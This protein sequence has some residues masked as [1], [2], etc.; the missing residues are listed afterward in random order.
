MRRRLFVA[1]LSIGLAVAIGLVAI[2]DHR[3]KQSRAN[4]AEL[5]EWYCAHVGT[6]CGGASSERIETSWERREI[7]YKVTVGG[8]V[9]AAVL[10][11]G[12]PVLVLA[13]R[14][15]APGR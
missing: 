1:C 10:V 3:H 6:R 13:R 9:A 4:R 5:G 12:A 14:A 8:L 15:G 2:A 11:A 7:G